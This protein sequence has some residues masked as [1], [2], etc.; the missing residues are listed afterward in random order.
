[1]SP[2]AGTARLSAGETGG[3]ALAAGSPVQAGD[4]L[5]RIVARGGEQPVTAPHDGVVLEWLIEDGDPVG[6]GQPL[7]RLQPAEGKEA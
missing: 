3:E 4:V 1:V 5:A 2:T 7:A 6:Q